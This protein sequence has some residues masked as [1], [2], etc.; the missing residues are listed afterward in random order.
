MRRGAVWILAIVMLFST[1]CAD[2]IQK[3]PDY[4]MEGY[5]G[6]VDYRVWE[7][8]LFFRRMQEKT[9]VSFELRQYT[10]KDRWTERKGELLA[11][12]NLP[13]VLFKA[14]LGSNE[15]RDLYLN[16]YIIDLKPYL[17]TYAPDLW[18]LLQDHPEWEKAITMPDGTIPALPAINTLQNND[19]MWINASWLKR[20]KLEMP[21]T[22][23]EL[24]EVLR[25]FKNDDPNGNYQQDEVPLAF[26]GMWELRFLGHAFGIIDNDYYVS[27]KDGVVTSSL[28]TDENR[29]FLTWLHQL[30]TEGLLDRNGFSTTDTLRQITDE[31]A[32]VPYGMIMTSTPLTILPQ[33]ALSQ[34]GMMDP[35]VYEGKQI[36]RDLLG[37]LVRGTFAITS[38]CK[39][40]ERLV[41][42][43]NFLYTEEGRRLAFYGA[44]GE[45]YLWNEDGMWEWAA[46]LQTVAEEIL[47]THTISE[48]GTAP[49]YENGLFQTQYR[50]EITRETIKALRNLKQYSVIPYPP[51]TLDAETEKRAAEIQDG[52][53][54]YAEKAMACFVTGDIELT[55]ENWEQFCSTVEEKGLQEMIGIW[56][57]AIR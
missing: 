15:V 34:Y 1:A 32:A 30:W 10:D 7:N 13:D 11:G 31:K 47:P 3:A 2:S 37:D 26:L 40:P 53:S 39:E 44:E 16:G 9:G 45:D 28:T 24:T 51:V 4:L 57:N 42:W 8:N 41:S 14:E 23:D 18:K 21:T 33:T 36:Y 17:E 22:A 19:A 54:R 43:V 38:A 27:E 49:G 6:G 12:Q 48:G 50:D 20:L 52:L 35:L 55:D 25:R 46:P 56:Q 29:A 5:D